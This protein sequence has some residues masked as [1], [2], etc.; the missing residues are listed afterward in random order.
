MCGHKCYQ[1]ICPPHKLP[2]LNKHNATVFVDAWFAN[3]G[4][5]YHATH[6]HYGGHCA[7]YFSLLRSLSGLMLPAGSW[8]AC[9]LPMFHVSTG[10]PK[11][12]IFLPST[13]AITSFIGSDM[14]LKPC[15]ASFIVRPSCCKLIDI[16]VQ[17]QLSKA[18][19][20]T[21]NILQISFTLARTKSWSTTLP[22]VNQIKPSR[23]HTSYG[24][25]SFLIRSGALSF[26]IHCHTST[27][28][29]GSPSLTISTLYCCGVP[30]GDG[31]SVFRTTSGIGGNTN[32]NAV[33]SI[34]LDMSSPPSLEHFQC[35]GAGFLGISQVPAHA[36]RRPLIRQHPAHVL[37]RPHVQVLAQKA[38]ECGRLFFSFMCGCPQFINFHYAM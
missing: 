22:C 36:T 11:C 24:M 15:R 8:V 32:A 23:S 3:T 28:H 20:C 12:S 26:G 38:V 27:Y 9:T 37:R 10:S 34:L 25:R 19:S 30:T 21:L 13:M 31:I 33:K 29:F 6:C 4:V 16:W 1:L 18:I 5:G 35:C 17:F 14:V 2:L 7:V